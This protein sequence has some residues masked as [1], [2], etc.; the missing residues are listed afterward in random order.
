MSNTAGLKRQSLR[1]PFGF[2]LRFV[3]AL[4]FTENKLALFVNGFPVHGTF[5]Y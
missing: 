1:E 3:L 2:C 5:M 4:Q